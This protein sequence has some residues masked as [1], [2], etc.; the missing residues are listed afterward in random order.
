MLAFNF[1]Q[2]FCLLGIKLTLGLKYSLIIRTVTGHIIA[3]GIFM[4]AN[5]RDAIIQSPM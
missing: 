5:S 3:T 2:G 4:S 1:V